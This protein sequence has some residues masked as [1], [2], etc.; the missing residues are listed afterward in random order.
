MVMVMVMAMVI[1]I[2]MGEHI[3]KCSYGLFSL[4]HEEQRIKSSVERGTLPQTDR[5][6]D[7]DQFLLC[8]GFV[9][10][11]VCFGARTYCLRPNREL[12]HAFVQLK[13]FVLTLGFQETLLLLCKR[14]KHSYLCN[15]LWSS[16]S[17]GM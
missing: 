10:A 4:Q 17:R 1:A 12:W 15:F 14:T 13:L 5:R 7:L 6:L 9:L 8:L 16:I 3:F 11:K 2:R